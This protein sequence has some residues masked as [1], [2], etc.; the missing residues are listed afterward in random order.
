M[1]VT[2]RVEMPISSWGLAPGLDFGL[3]PFAITRLL[4]I[5][6]FLNCGDDFALSG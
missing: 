2:S 5:Q 3:R 6:R 1:L 4:G